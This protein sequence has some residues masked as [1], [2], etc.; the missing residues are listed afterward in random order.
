M[1]FN[2]YLKNHRKKQNLTLNKAAE[3]IGISTSYLSSLESGS[4]HAPSFDTLR[5]TADVLELSAAE[6]HQL[7]DLAAETKQPPVLADDLNEY[8]YQNPNIRGLLRYAMECGMAENDW[9][10]VGN[11]VRKNYFY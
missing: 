5:K 4:R 11:F 9:D 6:R 3:M 10:K 7:Y 1:N 8:I 2:E